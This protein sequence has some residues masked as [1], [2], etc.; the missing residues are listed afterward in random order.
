[1]KGTLADL[2]QRDIRTVR[3]SCT[4]HECK[5]RP[6]TRIEVADLVRRY[7]EGADLE[8]LAK[9][10]RCRGCGQLATAFWMPSWPDTP[11]G[12]SAPGPRG[13]TVW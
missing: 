6:E 5:M 7:G 2:I 3:V 10:L 13:R 12:L 1:M 9:K 8:A 11:M 4:H